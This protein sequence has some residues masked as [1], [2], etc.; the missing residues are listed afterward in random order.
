MADSDGPSTQDC[1]IVVTIIDACI[2]HFKRAQK[3]VT[4]LYLKSNNAANLKN[5]I[6]ICYLKDLNYTH[7]CQVK[8]V[9]A[10]GYVLSVPI[11]GKDLADLRAAL[12]NSK[13]NQEVNM[14]FSIDTSRYQAAVYDFTVSL[15]VE[16]EN[17]TTCF[18]LH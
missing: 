4:K 17:P 1:S 15:K 7:D 18:T 16:V 6:L 13:I 11:D 14:G 8:P 5:E 3:H 9:K 12:C 2:K 10:V